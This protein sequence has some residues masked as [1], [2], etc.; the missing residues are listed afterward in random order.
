MKYLLPLLASSTLLGW[1]GCTS[2]PDAANQIVADDPVDVQPLLVNWIT[3]NVNAIDTSKTFVVAKDTCFASRWTKEVYA[4][5]KFSPRWSD[6]GKFSAAADSFLFVLRNAEDWG[7]IPE[8]YH[9]P[10]LDSLV[11][12]AYDS[13]KE[14][15]NI[16]H[17][18]QADLLL[19]DAYFT[20][21]VHVATGRLPHDSS[22][23]REW[24]PQKLDT[25]I[26]ALFAADV[27]AKSFR[28]TFDALE[29]QKL[30]YQLVKKMLYQF[31]R[32][33]KDDAWKRI[34]SIEKDTNAFY[35]AVKQRLIVTGEYDTTLREGSDSLR[36][37]AA[38]KVF[39]KK[40]ALE[41]DGK[42]GKNTLK[43]LNMTV[44]DRK[45][46]MA[47][48]ME[49]WRLEP[50]S[51]G[52]RYLFV[53]IPA[54]TMKVIEADTLVMQSRIVVGAVKTQTPELTSRI[55]D[56]TLY[57]YWTVPYSIAWKEILPAV[58]RDTNYLH[59]KHFEVIGRNGEV[60]PPSQINWKKL[61]KNNLP[62][63]F[64][65][66]IG[67]DNS[68]GVLK[69][70]FANRF[71]V[72]MHDTNSKGYFSRDS[73]ALSHGC[74]RLEKFKDLAHFL[75]REDS[76]RLPADT[77]D[78]WLGQ[79]QQRKIGVRKPLTLYV[80]YFTCKLNED[81]T[82]I[83]PMN[84]VYDRDLR[85]MNT[86]YAKVNR[87]HPELAPVVSPANADKPKAVATEQKKKK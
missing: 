8:D 62:Y 32:Q 39:Q 35:E 3:E 36:L 7:L 65:Q 21:A 43:A 87:D 52:N 11:H 30:E 18:A 12:T 4:A 84:D 58:Q 51:Y 28:K 19:T 47:I 78:I 37:S 74:M 38:I 14:Q 31:R 17:L 22:D 33:W 83:V 9:A 61:S 24:H 67:E 77:F 69:F 71:G 48:N 75:I 64:R 55:T 63:K 66:N 5:E 27:K 16:T 50:A 82:A 80:R 85:L 26:V 2:S 29:P 54:F 53:N 70:N 20:F 46:Q 60:I 57:P 44:V 49:R 76:T 13:T 81:S 15:F 86:L 79:Q 25:N 72:Y 10:L 59:K 73:R 56:M 42:L 41:I 68:L 40:L 6:Q 34:P 23:V 1:Y 45:R